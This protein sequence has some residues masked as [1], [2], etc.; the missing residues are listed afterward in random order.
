MRL[1][2]PVLLADKFNKGS[3]GS[4]RLL[5]L[6]KA[7]PSNGVSWNGFLTDAV[8]LSNSN[9]FQS[10]KQYCLNTGN[11]SFFYRLKNIGLLFNKTNLAGLPLKLAVSKDFDKA[12]LEDQIS[13]TCGEGELLTLNELTNKIPLGQL[14]FKEEAAGKLRVF[15]MVDV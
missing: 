8:A 4:A 5:P 12:L 9:I 7:S 3:I 6:E 15:A 10:V 11:D 1:H 13:L 2:V 14:S